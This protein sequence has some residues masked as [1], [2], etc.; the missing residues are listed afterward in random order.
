[1][2]AGPALSLLVALIA[3]ALVFDLLNGLHDAANSIATV[4][5]TR[6]LS[7]HV[8]V[9]W[10]AFF[11]F[12]AFLVFHLK[13]AATMGKGI[14]DPAIVNNRVIAATLIAAC[15]WDLITWYWGLPTSSSHALI[16]GMVGAALM[17]WLVRSPNANAPFQWEGIGKTIMFLVLAPAI[18]FAVGMAICSMMAW[19]FRF[20]PPRR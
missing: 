14:I 15:A 13:V 5:S 12:I 16:G 17:K 8:A 20:M 4:V 2:D 18:G 7:P 3:V 10:A 19:L 1:M 6:V 9:L 11:N